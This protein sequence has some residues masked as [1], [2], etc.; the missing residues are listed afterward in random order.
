MWWWWLLFR[1]YVCRHT[2]SESSVRARER[3]KNKPHI[4]INTSQPSTQVCVY[5]CKEDEDD[6]S[7][8]EKKKELNAQL[9]SDKWLLN[10]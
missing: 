10:T 4:E 7:V 9:I 5:V 2:G 1:F 6:G 8:E 3:E